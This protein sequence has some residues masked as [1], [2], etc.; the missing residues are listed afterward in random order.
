MRQIHGGGDLPLIECIN[1]RKG[2]HAVRW[3]R[4]ED[5]DNGYSYMEEDIDHKPTLDEV[6]DI[7]QGWIDSQTNIRIVSGFRWHGIDVWL[8][9]ENQR[10]FAEAQRKADADASILPIT[11]KIGENA[12]K[13]PIY[14][15]FTEVAELDDFYDRAFAHINECLVEG[16]SRKDSMD[17]S[18]YSRL[19]G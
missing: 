7:V 19:I 6:K 11:F 15:T 13:E 3:D 1:H 14:H 16:W 9:V 18:E 17:W 4:Q 2:T 5:G 12:S 10:N 8:S